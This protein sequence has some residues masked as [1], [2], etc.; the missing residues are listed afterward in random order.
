MVVI[1][2]R[3]DGIGDLW[4]A[5][6]DPIAGHFDGNSSLQQLD[7]YNQPVL[8]LDSQQHARQA[9]QRT[10]FYAYAAPNF[11]VSTGLNSKS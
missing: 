10:L 11:Q 7:A 5:G 9:T 3:A 2:L 4:I 1:E 6:N 8:T